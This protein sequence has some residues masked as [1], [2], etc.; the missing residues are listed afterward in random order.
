MH[1][2][3]SLNDDGILVREADGVVGLYGDLV[4]GVGVGCIKH[5]QFYTSQQCLIN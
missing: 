4:V 1:T 5:T 3:G 2:S